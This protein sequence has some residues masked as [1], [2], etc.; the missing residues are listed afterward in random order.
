MRSMYFAENNLF[1]PQTWKK[2]PQRLRIIQQQIPQQLTTVF[3]DLSG[4]QHLQIPSIRNGH[5]KED[6]MELMM[7]Q[8]AQMY[9]VIM[10]NITMAALTSFGYSTQPQPAVQ[11]YLRPHHQVPQGQLGLMYVQ[12]QSITM[13]L[14]ANCEEPPSVW[15]QY[16]VWLLDRL[17]GPLPELLQLLNF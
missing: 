2:D 14:T 11:L 1:S 12:H 4:P 5:V 8:N 3:Q 17:T 16:H 13:W 15:S 6:L 9:Q 7:I 10:N